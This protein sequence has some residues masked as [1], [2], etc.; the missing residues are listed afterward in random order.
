MNSLLPEQWSYHFS[1]SGQSSCCKTITNVPACHH[2]STYVRQ[3]EHK[4]DDGN[5]L[6][7]L[8]KLSC[9]FKYGKNLVVQF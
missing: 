1:A 6:Q 7:R 3:I 2:A 8:K 5:T 9:Q 4:Q